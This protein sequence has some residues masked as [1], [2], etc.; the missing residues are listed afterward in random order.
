MQLTNTTGDLISSIAPETFT[1]QLRLR[2]L[3][4]QPDFMASEGTVVDLDILDKALH[5][6]VPC[7]SP[8]GEEGGAFVV[9]SGRLVALEAIQVHKGTPDHPLLEY[10]KKH[11]VLT[12]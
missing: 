12:F 6:S 5:P 7:R 9:E 3:I 4:F 1:R 10:C 2:L 11:M 8:D